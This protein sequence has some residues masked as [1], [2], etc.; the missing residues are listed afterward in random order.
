MDALKREK[1]TL[2]G[3][4]CDAVAPDPIGGDHAVTRDDQRVAVVGAERARRSGRAGASCEHGELPVGDDVPPRNR[5]GSGGK[6]ALKWCRPLEVDGN[7]VIRRP[8]SGEMSLD[9][10]TQ[11][12]GKLC[13]RMARS[14][15]RGG[16]SPQTRDREPFTRSRGR[17]AQLRRGE[18]MLDDDSIAHPDLTHAPTGHVVGVSRH[19]HAD[20][21]TIAA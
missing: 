21:N 17:D 16:F 11:I 14:I 9:P 15:S 7:A 18:L 4:A 8:F 5:P 1:T 20:D 13:P 2:Q 6:L 19:A 10:P 12:R 3:R